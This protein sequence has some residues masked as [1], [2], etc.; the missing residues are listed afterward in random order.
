MNLQEFTNW[1]LAQGSVGKYD[2]GGFVGQCVS[3][4]NQYC[5]RVLNVPAGAWGN[6]KDWANDNNPNRAYFGEVNNIQVGDVI[7]YGSNF[8]G[9]YGHIGVGLGNGQILDQNGRATLKVATGAIYNGYIAI[10]RRKGETNMPTIVNK[11]LQQKILNLTLAKED[12][13]TD[14]NYGMNGAVEDML[15]DIDRNPKKLQILYPQSQEGAKT[16]SPGKYLVK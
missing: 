7:V 14:P 4:V 1:A 13:P 16:L 12:Q 3:L 10:L 11:E 9:G 6:A 8:G 5:Y 15:S 2:D